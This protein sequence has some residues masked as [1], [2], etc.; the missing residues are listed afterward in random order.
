MPATVTPPATAVQRKARSLVKGMPSVARSEKEVD[1]G[2]SI[3]VNGKTFLQAANMAASEKLLAFFR[4][5]FLAEERSGFARLKRVPDSRVEESLA[6]Y[7]SLSD[8]D[9]ASFVDCAAHY[10]HRTC[11]F[12]VEA[13]DIDHT[14]HPFFARWVDP[15]SRFPFRSNRNVPLLRAA[16]TQYKMDRHRGAPSCISEEL[17][18]LA[19]SVRS[20]K[21]PALRKRVRATLDRFGYQ[22]TDDLGGHRCIWEGQEFEVNVDFGASDAQLRYSVTP[23]EFRQGPYRLSRFC[24]EVALGMGFGHWNYI[25]EENVDDVFLLFE[26]LI[27]YAVDL[28]GRMREAV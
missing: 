18:Q 11:G 6:W 15:W 17:F 4:S 22:K 9:R 25:V 23:Y 21:A 10:A 1:F 27:K 16:V 19:E 28:P 5:E 14:N 3:E 8:P 2:G 7:Q 20:L 12:V 13:P 24:F 26:E